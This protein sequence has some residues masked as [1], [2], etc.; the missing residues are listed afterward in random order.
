[1]ANRNSQQLLESRLHDPAVDFLDNHRSEYHPGFANSL[2]HYDPRLQ[3]Y[4]DDSQANS[5]G[6][7]P[8]TTQEPRNIESLFAE[9]LD[10]LRTTTEEPKHAANAP[11]RLRDKHSWDEVEKEVKGAQK[12]YMNDAGNFR[13]WLRKAGD[14]SGVTKPYLNLIPNGTYTSILSVGGNMLID[15]GAPRPP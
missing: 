2:A 7:I 13:K 15:V 12:Q 1:M 9:A 4:T 14:R 5:T 6:L 11:F 10:L 8:T 3:R